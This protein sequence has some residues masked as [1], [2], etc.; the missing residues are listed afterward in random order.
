MC[1]LA[2]KVT[3]YVAFEGKVECK[4]KGRVGK[5]LQKFK[6][7]SQLTEKKTNQQYEIIDYGFYPNSRE[8]LSGDEGMPVTFDPLKGAER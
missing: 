1:L 2:I 8:E 3:T 7:A 5:R 4:Y 6:I